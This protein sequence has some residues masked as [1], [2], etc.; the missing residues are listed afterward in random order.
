MTGE[1]LK[2]IAVRLTRAHN[3]WLWAFLVCLAWLPVRAQDFQ[4]EP[5]VDTYLKLNSYVR[6]YFS[7]ERDRDTDDPVQTTIGPSI[8][9]YL[10]P[11]IKLRD[12]TAFDLDD[13]KSRF[14]VVEAGYRY[15][16]STGTA[17]TNRL[18]LMTTSNYP[19]R[20]G[21]LI[22]DRNRADLDWKAKGF[23]WRYRNKFTVERT[24]SVRSYHPI[25]YVAVEPYYTSQYNKW[26]TTALYAGCWLP[27]PRHIQFGP[28]YEHDNNT[29]K[30]RPT[31][32]DIFAFTLQIYVAVEPK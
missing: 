28:Y 13:S 1:K 25:P 6:T 5:E 8:E 31:Q 23:F 9:F 3:T 30:K 18:Q 14:F 10:K 4:F 29:G 12:V 2:S 11:L 22:S 32:E 17:G 26:S 24:V 16:T 21:F 20:G 19:L 27:L 15:I 7:V